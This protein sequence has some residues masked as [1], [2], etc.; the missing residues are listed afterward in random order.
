MPGLERGLLDD[1]NAFRAVHGLAPVRLS[2]ELTASAAQH[3]REMA[4]DGY[5]GHAS[6]GGKAFWKRIRGYY[7]STSWAVWSVGENLLWSAPGIGAARALDMWERSPEHL[8]NLLAPR[9]REIGISA[10]RMVAAPG[11]FHGRTVTIVTTDFG[12]RR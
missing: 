12:V 9:W 6:A 10:V 8:A 3:S 11:I 7:D 1:I 5:F 2:P 4:A